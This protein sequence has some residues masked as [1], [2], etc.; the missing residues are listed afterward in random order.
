MNLDQFDCDAMYHP[1][2]TPI[3]EID[4]L[5]E[6]AP[7]LTASDVRKMFGIDVFNPEGE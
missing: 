4:L 7:C 3:I 5:D 6:D 1:S 2:E